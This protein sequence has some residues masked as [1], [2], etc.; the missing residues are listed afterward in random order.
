MLPAA[1]H[2]TYSHRV[3][4]S[5]RA[6][7]V[8]ATERPDFWLIN[9]VAL[10]VFVTPVDG[11]Y[12]LTRTLGFSV[13]T[14][15]GYLVTVLLLT[16]IGSIVRRQ[17]RVF[18]IWASAFALG[19]LLTI[20]RALG[21]GS[22]I[23]HEVVTVWQM[24]ALWAFVTAAASTAAGRARV[25]VALLAGVA[26]TC[27]AYALLHTLGFEVREAADRV[28]SVAGFKPNYAGL[29]AAIAL[30]LAAG[31]WNMHARP[32][33]V[34]LALV[35]MAAAYVLVLSNSRGM[36][37]AVVSGLAIVIWP[38]LSPSRP[39][40]F[41]ALC[42]LAG[43]LAVGW[44]L[45]GAGYRATLREAMVQRWTASSDL[46]FITGERNRIFSTALEVSVKHPLGVGIGNAKYAIGAASDLD[47]T[48]Y[49]ADPSEQVIDTHNEYLRVVIECGWLGGCLYLTGWALLF[50]PAYRAYRRRQNI[51][52]LALLTTAAV[53][54]MSGTFGWVKLPWVI[55]GLI[56]GEQCAGRS[57]RLI[58]MRAH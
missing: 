7:I 14:M 43:I 55:F 1:Q 16:R 54:M 10:L 2:A 31:Y 53:A 44:V 38:T 51:L 32:A 56:A 13:T 6:P 23:D 26:V 41:G 17:P 29:V 24:L 36:Q 47:L 37:L 48:M 45:L 4:P 39:R 20:Q 9:L 46:D 40:A 8:S 42:A 49:S 57:V 3:R 11:F 28:R 22:R 15:T 50:A 19:T 33:R 27:V 21:Q 25:R 30:V 52:P 58:R 12:L 5:A 35:A 34:R 18:W